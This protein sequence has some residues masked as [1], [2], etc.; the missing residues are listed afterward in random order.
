MR[1][2]ALLIALIVSWSSLV[3]A[4]IQQAW[5]AKYN[6]NGI[7][8][9]NHQAL[10]MAL[11]SAGNIYVLGVSENANTN[12]GY[13]VVKYA[14]NGNQIWA[15]RYDSTNFPTASPTGFALD[16]S[17]A[18]VV[19]GNAVTAKYDANGN[20]LWTAPYN[21]SAIAID[22]RRNVCITDVSSN[23]LTMKLSP[24]GSNIWS[25]TWTYQGLANEGQII[26]VDNS[27]NVYVAGMQT[28]NIPR[29]SYQN[30]GLLKY[31]PNGNG[32]WAR[33]FGG[34][35]IA[36]PTV[37]GL[38]VAG[39]E[40]VYI[41]FN[42]ATGLG[43]VS[44]YET[45]RVNLDGSEAWN[46][47]NPTGSFGSVSH[48]LALDN[49]GNVLVTGGY[50][51]AAPMAFTYLT[52]KLD[53]NG[54]YV[55]TNF[56]PTNPSG[57]CSTT[58]IIADQDDSWY[59]TGSFT[60]VIS[61]DDIVTIKYDSNG[62][63]KWVQEYD[64]PAHRNDAGNAIAVDNSGN[65]YVAGYETETNGFTSMILIKYSS[66]SGQKQSNGNFILHASG[67]PGESFDIQASTNLQSW[68]D[69]GSVIADTNGIALFEDTNA[70][71]FPVRFYY[72]IPK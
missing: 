50:G 44:G 61:G 21:A 43:D 58:A 53:T 25:E 64:G 13:V 5:V 34:G 54:S 68:Q 47:N 69:L 52:Y 15:A 56:Y 9:G 17:N 66:V 10:K 22:S 18:V 70:P 36:G 14:P 8:N 37:V 40:S 27:N 39:D 3:S 60:N 45:S 19:T 2:L 6:N 46:N 51:Y 29:T 12:T 28:E 7:P 63:Q 62:N 72:T 48:G 41:E 20:P 49:K 23:F 42:F 59:V 57:N 24:T 11:D 31:D 26:A 65:V 32:L 16:S 33:S 67:S 38:A 4:Q 55:W 30:V 1:I 71:L 35:P